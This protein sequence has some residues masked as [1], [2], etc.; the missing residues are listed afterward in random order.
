MVL[1]MIKLLD[2]LIDQLPIILLA[3]VS[4]FFMWGIGYLI[5]A[6]MKDS[7]V[8]KEQCVAAGNQYVKGNCVK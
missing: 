6:D 1:K 3:A 5:L 2:N 4:V 7:A 8:F